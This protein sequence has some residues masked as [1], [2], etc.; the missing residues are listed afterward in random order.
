MKILR[1]RKQMFAFF[2]P[3]F[4]MGILYVNFIVKQYIAEPG[5][6]SVYFLKQYAAVDIIAGEYMLYLL[7]V[8]VLPCVFLVGLAFTKMRKFSA[9]AFLLWTGFSSGMLLTMAVVGM[10][11]KGIILCIVGILPHFLCYIP[12]CIVVLWYCWMY[13]QNRWN[14]Q[15]TVFVILMGMMGLILEAHVNPVLMKAFL[16]T[17]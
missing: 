10:G 16:G 13:P 4:L 15:K 9:V 7:R 6:F 3:G 12:A 8:R 5:I 11:V 2:M 1:S 14:K 17:L